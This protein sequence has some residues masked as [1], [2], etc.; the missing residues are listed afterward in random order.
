[1]ESNLTNLN[2]NIEVCESNQTF[3]IWPKKE[4][5]KPCGIGLGMNKF[6]GECNVAM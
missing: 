3:K 1:M 5:S 2:N 6:V 4:V